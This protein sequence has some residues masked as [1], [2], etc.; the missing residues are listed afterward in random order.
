MISL[1]QLVNEHHAIEAL[2]TLVLW[3]LER[4]P[5]PPLSIIGACDCIYY[6]ALALKLME[7]EA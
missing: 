4:I 1:D 2:D 3:A 7:R 6:V 5:P